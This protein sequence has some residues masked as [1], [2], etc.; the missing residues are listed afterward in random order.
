MDPNNLDT[1][2]VSD[3]EAIAHLERD[4]DLRSSGLCGWWRR[5]DEV[6]RATWLLVLVTLV[7]NAGLVIANI[8][9]AVVGRDAAKDAHEAYVRAA[10]PGLFVTGQGDNVHSPSLIV[11]TTATA[12]ALRLGCLARTANAPSQY[13]VR[14]ADL[15]PTE[16]YPNEIPA[17][18]AGQSI[19]EHVVAND[20]ENCFWLGGKPSARNPVVYIFFY[21]LYRGA[22]GAPHEAMETLYWD[23]A[24][25]YGA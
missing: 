20:H 7:L 6:A 12:Y 2:S 13:N 1:I 25:R 3:R 23:T 18:I 9:T 19:V 24:L 22:D 10:T 21:G 14:L 11:A 5:I 16:P 15:T 4:E 8:V 17:L